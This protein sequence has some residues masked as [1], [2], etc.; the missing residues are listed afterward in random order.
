MSE[1][2]RA[3]PI[4]AAGLNATISPREELIDKRRSMAFAAGIGALGPLYLDDTRP[5][6]VVAPAA[7]VA[8][9]EWPLF[10]TSDYLSAI[11]RDEDTIFKQ[12]VHGF[13][14]SEF[15][16]P[17]RPGD[18]VCTEGRIVE[19]RQ[20]PAGT[21]V[22]VRLTTSSDGAALATSWFGAL[23]R[24]TLLDGSPGAV[25]SVP[26]LRTEPGVKQGVSEPLRVPA[27]QA[28]V[29]TECADIW[30][31][32]HTEREFARAAG[33]PDIVLHGTC[34]WAMALQALAEGHRPGMERPFTR[35][36]TRF[37]GYIV[38]GQTA[39]LEHG[40]VEGGRIAFVVRSEDGVPALTHAFV[41]LA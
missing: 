9:L 35:A 19:M 32:I 12:L 31:P 20:T 21:L 8:A 38:P 37:S 24:Q 10:T 16:R 41:E 14:V 17:I 25:E 39:S 2:E 18:R 3:V 11:G 15:H 23:Y 13:Q 22:I 36:G 33:L 7:I 1:P 26:E 4:R 28:H 40:P 27:G 6:G 34:T 5:G 29:Y 30:N